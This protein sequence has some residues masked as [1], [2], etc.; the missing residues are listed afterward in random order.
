MA[1][2]KIQQLRESIL[3]L[4]AAISAVISE[5][6]SPEEAATIL[7]EINFLKRD[8]STVYDT[9]AHSFGE[10]MG[11]MESILLEDGTVIEK[12]SA[13]DRKGWKHSELAS[14]VADKLTQMSVDMDSG[15]ILKTPQQIAE[16]MLMYCAPSYWR[17]KELGKIGINADNYS[18]VGELRTSIIVRKPK[19]SF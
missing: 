6:P 4:D 17:I 16:E 12:K 7:A 14:A 19:T 9:L 10:I 5:N 13:Y 11:S 1:L 8:L 15:E 18:N 2:D 3:E